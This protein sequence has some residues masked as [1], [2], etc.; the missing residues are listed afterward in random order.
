[1]I[2]ITVGVGPVIAV[3]LLV[4]IN[5]KTEHMEVSVKCNIKH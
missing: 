4:Q 1:M 2:A 5:C 3:L